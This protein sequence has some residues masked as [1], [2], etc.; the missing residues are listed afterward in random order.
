MPRGGVILREPEKARATVCQRSLLARKENDMKA[1]VVHSPGD[2]SVREVEIPHVGAEDVLVKVRLCGICG[3]DLQ[4]YKLGVHPE[5]GI[6]ADSGL[7]VGHEYVGDVVQVGANVKGLDVGDRI[8]TIGAFGAMAEYV[9]LGPET[10][11]I[12]AGLVFKMPPE[13]SDEEAATIEPLCVSLVGMEMSEPAAG[14]TVVVLGAGPIGLGLV[15]C[16]KALTDTRVIAVERS[17]KR[18][19]AAE[20]AGADAVIRADEVDPYEKVLELTGSSPVWGFDKPAA[21]VDIVFDCAGHPAGRPGPTACQQ[22]MWMLRFGGRLIL[23]AAYEAPVEL[24]LLPIIVKQLKVSGSLLT[25]PELVKRAIELVRTKK[26][27][28]KA[29]VSHVYPIEKAKEAFE[30]QMNTAESLK[31]LIRP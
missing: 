22:G 20:Q 14:E 2:L 16:L 13:I 18:L 28:R 8:I 6:P 12:A 29:V 15:Q 9:R 25:S 19:A 26:V 24:D 10:P 23:V 11:A 7:I 4:F 3:S 1:V 31:V 30:M 5:V 27:D 21:G 17:E